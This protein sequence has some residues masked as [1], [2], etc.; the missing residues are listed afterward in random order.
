[1]ARCEQFLGI[2]H[3]AWCWAFANDSAQRR[4]VGHIRPLGGVE[5]QLSGCPQFNSLLQ[6]V[7][8]ARTAGHRP[9]RSFTVGI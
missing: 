5:H 1:M 4:S 3:A 8:S 2:D 6:F 7:G 9:F